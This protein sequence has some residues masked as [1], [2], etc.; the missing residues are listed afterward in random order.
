MPQLVKGGKHVYGWSKVG[1]SGRIAVPPEAI[2]EY[3]FNNPTKVFLMTASKRSGGFG[4]TTKQLLMNSQLSVVLEKNPE[5]ASFHLPEAKTTKIGTKL[6]C[7]T[8]MDANGCIR[9]PLETLQ[10]YGISAGDRLLVGRGSGLALA[11]IIKGPIIEE[12]K[13]HSELTTF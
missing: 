5:L 11:F 4:L 2:K 9:V 7:W 10:D 6:Y 12:A 3:H 8:T 1:D 13:K